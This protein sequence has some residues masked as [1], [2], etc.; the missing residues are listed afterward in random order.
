M[1]H[2]KFQAAEPSGSEA[3]DFLNRRVGKKSLRN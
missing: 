2:P 3:D 1:Q